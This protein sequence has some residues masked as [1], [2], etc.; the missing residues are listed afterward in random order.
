MP[1]RGTLS[2]DKLKKDFGFK[3][4]YPIEKGIPNYY[5]WYKKFNS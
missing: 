1:F 5:D 2:I 4:S 3:P